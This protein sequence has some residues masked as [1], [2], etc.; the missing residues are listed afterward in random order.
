MFHP[1]VV[2]KL[3]LTLTEIWKACT[4]DF[5]AKH[6]WMEG[7]SYICVTLNLHSYCA[8]A[9]SVIEVYMLICNVNFCTCFLSSCFV[10][11]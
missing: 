1:Y 2:K 6:V 4:V 8:L 11:Q 5:S 9:M 10:A 7:K 3:A